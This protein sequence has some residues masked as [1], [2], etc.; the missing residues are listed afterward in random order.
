MD[1]ISSFIFVFKLHNIKVDVKKITLYRPVGKR[2]LELIQATDFSAFPPRLDWQ[3][4]FYP[5]LNQGYAEKIASDWNTVDSFS[6]F[7]GFVTKFDLEE[8]YI[9]QFPVK[10]VGGKTHNELWIPAEDLEHFNSKIIGKIEI[11][12]AFFGTDFKPESTPLMQEL[13]KKFKS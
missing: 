5:V 1:S 12:N 13:Y 6:G 10:N 9:K 7:V 3:P 8:Q 2:E 11:I 4:I